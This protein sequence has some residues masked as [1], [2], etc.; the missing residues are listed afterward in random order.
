[1]TEM[2]FGKAVKELVLVLWDWLAGGGP[3][4]ELL[5]GWLEVVTGAVDLDDQT[6]ETRPSQ[7]G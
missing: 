5:L 7:G 6:Q 4:L 3:L 2:K 1:M